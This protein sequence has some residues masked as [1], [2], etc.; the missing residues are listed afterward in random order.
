VRLHCAALAESLLEAELFG[1]EKGAFTGADK[2]RSGFIE[3]AHGGTLFLD[4]VGELPPQTQVKLLRVVENRTVVRLGST[5]ET[6]VDVRFVCATHRDMEEEVKAGRFRQDLYYRISAFT[7]RV[8]PLRER[9][10]EIPILAEQYLR[11]LAS[12]GEMPPRLHPET[13]AALCRYA[14]PGNV[15]ELRNAMEHALVNVDGGV[16][17]PSHLPAKIAGSSAAPPP[18]KPPAPT[19]PAAP[20]TSGENV[21]PLELEQI[22]RERIVAAL[23]LDSGN[24]TRAAAR[25]G[26][27]R[28]TLIYKL[29]KYGIR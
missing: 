28:R 7:I 23:A 6:P 13:A 21:L 22:E 15:R 29:N 9:Q 17:L 5:T 14:W 3:A 11:Q 27:S 1:N 26:V 2:R 12:G 16:V 8:P 10:I 20:A 19:A 18:R 24:R 4:E 25:L